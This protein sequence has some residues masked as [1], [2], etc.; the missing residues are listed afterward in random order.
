M[1][2]KGSCIP[3]FYVGVVQLVLFEHIHTVPRLA[4]DADIV[5][6]RRE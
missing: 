4:V 3:V 2:V 1:K 6:K 5:E